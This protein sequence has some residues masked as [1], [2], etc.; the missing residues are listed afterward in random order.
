MELKNSIRILKKDWKVSV[1]NKE[2]LFPMI[3]LP[4]LFTIFL[5]VVML[6]GVIAA[7]EEFSAG[8][9]NIDIVQLIE[10]LLVIPSHYNDY[11]VGALIMIK[12]LILPMFLFIPG[13]L[14]T[15]ISSDSFAGE[16]ERKTMESL[17]LLPITKTELIIGKVLT[18]FIPSII[19]CFLCFV[20]TGVVINAMLFPYLEGNILFFTDLSVILV[21]FLLAPLLTLL[22]IQIS[23]IIS[24]RSKDL[25]SAQSIAG[26]LITPTIAILFVQMFNPAFL[27]VPMILII[28]AILAIFC[29]IFV[30]IANRLLD[31]EKLILML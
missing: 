31:L 15:V 8:F 30:N 9:G 11:L 29:L 24:S 16:K 28:S 7:P 17:A 21:A 18:S 13:I 25:K 5:P 2:I 27:S 1:R 12:L 20:G 10:T 26:A 23:V 6:I 4:V 19:I 3:L 22:N 14:P